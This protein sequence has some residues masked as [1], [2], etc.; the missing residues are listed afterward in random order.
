MMSGREGARL[1]RAV[2]DTQDVRRASRVRAARPP[3]DE[4]IG[5][6][7]HRPR[8]AIAPW[9]S[10]CNHRYRG[11]AAFAALYRS[12][13]VLICG[14]GVT[15]VTKDD[16]LGDTTMVIRAK[17][18]QATRRSGRSEARCIVRSTAHARPATTTLCSGHQPRGGCAIVAEVDS[19]VLPFLLISWWKE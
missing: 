14:N 9:Y 3:H 16:L 15:H 1:A 5:H 13:P 18:C 7:S 2:D 12:Q 19:G 6:D 17:A 11:F 8:R 10:A 4:P